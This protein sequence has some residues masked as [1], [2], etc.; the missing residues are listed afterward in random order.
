MRFT[1]S[2]DSEV[3][4]DDTQRVCPVFLAV[5]AASEGRQQA[6]RLSLAVVAA[7]PVRS[8]PHAVA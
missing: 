6:A 4:I 5:K 1:I 2:G 8:S 3:G 7:G